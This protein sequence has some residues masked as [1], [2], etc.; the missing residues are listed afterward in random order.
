MHARSYGI[1][2]IR[3]GDTGLKTEGGIKYIIVGSQ[4]NA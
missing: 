3:K 1:F 2:D 4:E